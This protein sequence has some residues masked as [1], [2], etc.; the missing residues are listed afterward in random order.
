[1]TALALI[2]E[3]PALQVPDTSKYFT[4]GYVAILGAIAAYALFLWVRG[5]RAGK[6]SHGR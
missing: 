1:M 2:Q 5:R 4:L 3:A 6:E